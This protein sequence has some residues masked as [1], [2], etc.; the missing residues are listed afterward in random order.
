MKK[1]LMLILLVSVVLVGCSPATGNGKDNGKEGD[2]NMGYKDPVATIKFKDLGEMTFEL[3]V[4][5]APQSVFNFTELA[6]SGYYDGLV[7]HRI[8]RGFVAQGGDPTGT[9]MGGPG[10]SIKGEF[11]G[12]GVDNPTPHTLGALA[13]ARSQHPDSA[14]SQFYIV[15]DEYDDMN[16][17]RMNKDYAAFGQMLSGEEL[18]EKMNNDYASNGGEPLQPLYIESIKVDTFD[19]TLPSPEKLGQ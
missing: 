3:K 7:M 12:N 14:G 17:A 9:G 4:N 19:Q 5:E 1:I 6:N 8:V 13:F 2:D 10:Y 16:M 18:L 15:L 11:A